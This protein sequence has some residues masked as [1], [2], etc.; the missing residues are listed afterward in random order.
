MRVITDKKELALF[1]E[2]EVLPV[3][4][5]VIADGKSE[6]IHFLS[7][8]KLGCGICYFTR[9]KFNVACEKVTTDLINGMFIGPTP[10]HLWNDERP[11]TPAITKRIEWMEN[12]IKEQK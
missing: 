9:N 6:D 5:K 1:L 12:F 8:N 2:A 10:F 4:K 11:L 3:Y 7:E